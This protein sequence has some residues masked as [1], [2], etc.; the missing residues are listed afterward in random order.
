MT[1]SQLMALDFRGRCH[2]TLQHAWA[3]M[4]LSEDGG[5]SL[6]KETAGGVSED[7]WMDGSQS[8]EALNNPS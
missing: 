1:Q 8:K 2:V 7:L 5:E 6:Q 3:A 4:L